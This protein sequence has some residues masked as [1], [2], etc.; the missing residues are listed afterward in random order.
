MTPIMSPTR[1]AIE[2]ELRR[3]SEA[4][5]NRRLEPL[6]RAA[7]GGAAQA[8][9]NHLAQPTDAREFGKAIAALERSLLDERLTAIVRANLFA[10]RLALRWL[11]DAETF[12]SPTQFYSL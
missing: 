9:Q 7:L 3:I 4:L 2:I 6:R 10:T 1:E 11:A 12:D 5:V 8:L